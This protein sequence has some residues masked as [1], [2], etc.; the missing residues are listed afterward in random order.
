MPIESA[1]FL[2]DLDATN[3]AGTD[4]RSQ[5]DN[6]IRLLKN[7]L[8]ATFPN[9]SKVFRF[10]SSGAVESANFSVSFPT[11]L[12]VFFFVEPDGGDITITLPDPTS[13]GTANEDGFG[14]YVMKSD[15]DSNA[16]LTPAG[17]QTI[18]GAS[19]YTISGTGQWV[20]LF[21]AGTINQWFVFGGHDPSLAYALSISS[22]DEPVITLTEPT[23]DT[24]EH[25][26]A[27][28]RLGSGAGA[29]AEDRLVGDGAN[30]V[31]Q[32]RRYI[33]STEIERLTTALALINI[34]FGVGASLRL[35]PD[36]YVDL[37]EIAAPA[38]PSANIARLYAKDVFGTSR[39]AYR[40]AV[41]TEWE[42][43]GAIQSEMEA[44]SAFN[45]WSSPGLQHYHP[46]HAKAW[47]RV[48]SAGSLLASYGVDSVSRTGT[49]VYEITLSTELS[50]TNY[51]VLATNMD[52]SDFATTAVEIIDATSFRVRHRDTNDDALRDLDFSVMVLGTVAS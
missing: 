47:A 2:S 7:V 44:A 6:H 23:N 5:G 33:G 26:I 31:T 52:A 50:D 41:A 24:S 48:S 11:D 42:L 46:G 13:G 32:R 45:M 29:V 30:A 14:F 27:R 43:R 10:P 34:I 25:T 3:P 37:T 8:K 39:L 18:M 36:G 15:G 28:Y 21:W 49:G 1:N 4:D 9:A 19:S 51:A 17:G 35:N 40:D 16:V 22:A 38:D 20:Y 12:N